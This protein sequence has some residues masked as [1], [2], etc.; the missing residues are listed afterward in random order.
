MLTEFGSSVRAALLDAKGE[1]MSQAPERQ[2]KSDL[3]DEYDFSRGVRGKY[4]ERYAAGS[5][6]VVLDPDVAAVFPTAEMVNEALRLRA[7]LA[8]E[9]A[10]KRSA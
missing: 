5:N 6:V 1:T 3:H 4:A 9:Q 10:D 8:R 7:R 2:P